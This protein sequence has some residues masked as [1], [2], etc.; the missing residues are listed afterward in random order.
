MIRIRACWARKA[1]VAT[2]IAAPVEVKGNLGS[3]I[4]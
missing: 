3:A 2:A 4:D 1:E